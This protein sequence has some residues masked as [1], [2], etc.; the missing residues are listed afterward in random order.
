VLGLT[1]FISLSGV[2]VP[3]PVFAA[4]VAKGYEDRAAG[5]WIA[6]G[7]GIVEFP[8]MALLFVG[9]GFIVNVPIISLTVGFAGGAVLV[10]MGVLMILMERKEGS[11][12][13]MPY[14]PVALGAIMTV[15]NPYWL[16]WWV[17]IGMTLML[18]VYPYA[19]VGFMAF[20]IVHW[21]CDLGWNGLVGATV[22]RAKR[23]W[24]EK[25]RK[26]AFVAV[27]VSLGLLGGWFLYSAFVLLVST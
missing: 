22:H 25:V 15:S 19:V 12:E 17:T 16:V 26:S 5:L 20:A 4:A 13:G 2:M 8:L 27:G 10:Y 23:F 14:H 7:H 6:A 11:T 18:M 1:A 3:G 24:S 21:S 9:L